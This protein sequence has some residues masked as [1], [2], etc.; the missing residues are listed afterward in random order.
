MVTGHTQ[1][2]DSAP[3][4]A[5][6]SMDSLVLKQPAN[7]VETH[8]MRMI[9]ENGDRLTLNLPAEKTHDKPE[10]FISAPEHQLRRLE[11]HQATLI[12]SPG[13]LGAKHE[14]ARLVSNKT[15][16]SPLIRMRA[17]PLNQAKS[18]SSI[19]IVAWP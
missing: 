11:K 18:E 13:S 17:Y 16:G 1:V 9:M 3:V 14:K 4:K 2:I 8:I 15:H 19:I 10:H 7:S 12:S 5:N 6:A